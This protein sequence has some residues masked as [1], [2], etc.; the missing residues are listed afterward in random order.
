LLCPAALHRMQSQIPAVV[1]VINRTYE[2]IKLPIKPVDN[3]ADSHST[4]HAPTRYLLSS[5]ICVCFVRLANALLRDGESA[6]NSH[7]LA[8]NFAKYSP[9]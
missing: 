3:S 9:I 5:N 7:V 4:F 8:F 6:R 2:S 1:C